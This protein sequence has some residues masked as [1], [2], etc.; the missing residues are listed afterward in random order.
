MDLDVTQLRQPAVV[1]AFRGWN[2]AG[3]AATSVVRHLVIGNETHELLVFDEGYYDLRQTRPTVQVRDGKRVLKWPNTCIAVC[4]TPQR[5]LLIVIGDE[6][7]FDWVDLCQEIL[8]TV[9]LCEAT[10]V[11]VLGSMNSDDPHT[12]PLPV[13]VEATNPDLVWGM[14]AEDSDYQGPTG[15]TGVLSM[16]AAEAGCEVVSMWVSTPLYSSDSEC[17]KATLALARRVS[18][19]LGVDFDWERLEL[20]SARWE[21]QV[22][23][24][25]DADSDLAQ[26]VRALE[27]DRD[28]SLAPTSGEDLAAQIEQFLREDK[29][30]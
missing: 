16:M 14:G 25:V 17:A 7:N 30:S 10:P 4:R 27:A 2:D 8:G 5:D 3:E 15:I 13:S 23:H 9:S 12:R 6:P 26:Y 11:V 21:S 20:A 29:E 19:V 28:E 18:E 24:L 22:S 1:A